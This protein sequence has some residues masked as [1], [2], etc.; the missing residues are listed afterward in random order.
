MG[1]TDYDEVVS[2]GR[3]KL[4]G[5]A[6]L[7]QKKKKKK[8][9]SSNKD[10]IKS[11]NLLLSQNP[12]TSGS[13]SATLAQLESLGHVVS[14]VEKTT[15]ERRFEAV[16]KKRMAEKA[17]KQALKTHKDRVADF[18]ERLEAQSEHFDIPKVGPG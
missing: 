6:G 17:K 10:R 7:P 11:D 15:A 13:S 5:T 3:L 14:R 16:Q 4:K 18:N 8:S 1:Q 12:S 9:S 2:G